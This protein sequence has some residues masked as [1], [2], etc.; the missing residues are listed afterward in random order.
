MGV[1]ATLRFRDKEKMKHAL[2]AAG[3]RTP[4]HA[5]ARTETECREAAERIGYPLIVKPIAGAGSADTHRVES[6]EELERILPMM[7]H[8]AEVSVEEFIDGEEYTFDTICAGGDIEF[9]NVSWYRPRPL[10]GRT[11]EWTSPQTVS[12]RD[13]DVPHLRAGIEMGRAVLRTLGFEDGF[14]HMEWFLPR[15]GRPVFGEIAAR[16]PGAVSVDIMNYACDGDTFVGW[17]E[18][19]CLGRVST[20]LERRYNAAVV[21]KRARG[22]GRI[23]AIHGLDR[24]VA[25]YRPHVMAIELLPVGAQRRDWKRTLLS[26]GWVVVRH[27]DL[28]ATC[29]M[30]DR[31]GTDLVLEAE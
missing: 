1:E 17:A 3:I 31:F 21:F 18:A 26:D 16:P 14:T 28:A 25:R 20:P 6:R 7:R 12:L 8:V 24:L 4:A 15:D 30:A 2:D 10:I 23:R 22:T 29:E 27:P 11:L 19:V 9:H 13:P 5:G